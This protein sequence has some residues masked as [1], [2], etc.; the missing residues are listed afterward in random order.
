MFV[1]GGR[2]RHEEQTMTI[3]LD[4]WHELGTAYRAW[5]RGDFEQAAL[6]AAGVADSVEMEYSDR[7]PAYQER[8]ADVAA[9]A[10]L[11]ERAAAEAA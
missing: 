11:L 4:K 2:A 10:R 9:D 7:S 5:R 1:V 6:E 3:E 8:A